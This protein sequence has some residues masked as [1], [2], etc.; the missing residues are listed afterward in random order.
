MK[1]TSAATGEDRMTKISFSNRFSASV[2]PSLSAFVNILAIVFAFELLIMHILPHT[3][4]EAVIDASLLAALSSPFIWFIIA[5]PLRNAAILQKGRAEELER[6]VKERT[7]QLLDLQGELVHSAKLATFG[8]LARSVGHEL[9]NPLGVMNNAVFFLKTIQV[10]ADETVGEYLAIIEEEIARCQSI[11]TDLLDFSAPKLPRPELVAVADL[12]RQNLGGAIPGHIVLRVEIAENLPPLRVDPLQIGRVLKNLIA[13]AV[14][15]MPNGGELDVRSEE[16]DPAGTL[17]LSV[18]DT[19]EG[20]APENV[21]KLFQPL[22]STRAR[23]IGMGLTICKNFVE[24]NG[25]TIAV[26][27]R[28]GVGTRF[29]LLLPAAGA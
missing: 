19:G 16:G 17:C 20:I 14:Q 13:N 9:R 2:H 3:F 24:V 23:G 29:T 6:K 21:E 22:F 26:E 15:A 27:S 8:W 5:R 1:E 28:V 18:T 4:L 11:I 7:Q 10:D 25:G 12:V